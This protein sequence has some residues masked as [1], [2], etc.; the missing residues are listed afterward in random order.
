MHSG[1]YRSKCWAQVHCCFI[2]QDIFGEI[3]RGFEDCFLSNHKWVPT[4]QQE[5]VVNAAILNNDTND[6]TS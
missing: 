3:S 6:T 5:T 1:G 4:Q 2:P